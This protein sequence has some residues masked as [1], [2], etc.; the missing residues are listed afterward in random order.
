M[1]A[2]DVNTVKFL[3]VHSQ[4]PLQSRSA[5]WTVATRAS[6]IMACRRCQYGTTAM[7]ERGAFTHSS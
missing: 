7:P 4:K 5:N 1:N 6:G 3:V 2:S